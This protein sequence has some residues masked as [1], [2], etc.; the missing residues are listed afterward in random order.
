MSSSKNYR[1]AERE[2]EARERG[3]TIPHYA[4]KVAKELTRPGKKG[5]ST[6]SKRASK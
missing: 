5:R 3:R 2:Q 4:G 1:E 6:P